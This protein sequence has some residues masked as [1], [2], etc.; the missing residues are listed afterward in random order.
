VLSELFDSK[1]VVDWAETFDGADM[2]PEYL[3]VSVPLLLINGTYGIGVGLTSVVPKHNLNEVIDATINLILNPDAKVVL[4]PDHCMKCHIIDTNWKQIC[5]TGTGNYRC[6]ADID[7]EMIN[8]QPVLVIKSIPDMTTLCNEKA[9]KGIIPKINEL[10]RE[11]KLPQIAHIADESKGENLRYEIWLKKGSDANYVRDYLYKHTKL[12]DTFTVNFEV[13]NGIEPLRLSYKAY[14]QYFIESDRMKKFRVYTNL[15][16]DAM[17]QWQEKQL[18]LKVMGSNEI[19]NIIYKIRHQKTIDDEGFIEYLIKTLKVT[20]LEA[21]YIINMETKKLSEAYYDKYLAQS[22]ELMSNAKEYMEKITNEELID[23]EIIEELT[24]FKKK[25]GQP[26][27]CKIIKESDDSNIPRGEFKIVIT[28]KNYIKKIPMNDNVTS[29]KGDNPKFIIKTENTECILL[30]DRN[31]KVFKYPVWKIPLSDKNSMG[32]DVRIIIKNLTS[33][34]ISLMYEPTIVELSKREKKHFLVV[35]TENNCIKKLDLE[36]FLMVTPSGI[37]YTKLNENDFVKDVCIIP[38]VLDIII[39][40]NHKA[41][42]VNMS[43]IPHY[44]RSAL[45]VA[46]M[47]TKETI[48]GLSVIYPDA[49]HIVVVTNTG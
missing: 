49:T 29:Y 11:G 35:A 33:D 36:D 18:Y 10:C 39:Y 3:P 26:R 32:I 15:Y 28:E 24:M 8:D 46:A 17:T 47:N 1:G 37:T 34:I 27:Q 23:K 13:M 19:D 31:G 7:I 16:Q 5:N 45:G 40:S 43:E 22:Q 2:E 12:Q 30:F 41:L 25:Y 20:D 42:R 6:R 9:D 38:E 48:D 4:V 21:H 14:I 44:K